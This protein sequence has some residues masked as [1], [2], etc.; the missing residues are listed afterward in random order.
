MVRKDGVV[1]HNP[2]RQVAVEGIDII[3]QQVLIVIDDPL[4]EGAVES[5]VVR[6]HFGI[7][8]IRPGMP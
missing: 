6:V 1:F 4:L 7:A 5:F 3:K 2:L 8:R